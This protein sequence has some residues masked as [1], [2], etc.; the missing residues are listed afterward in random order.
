MT[1]ICPACEK[2]ALVPKVGEESFPYEGI[3]LS[4]PDFEYSECPVCREELVL[5]D[6]AR[7]NEGRI[8]DAKRAHDGLLTSSDIVNWR[9][10]WE[11]T[12][13]EAAVLLGGGAN[14]FSKYERGEVIQSKAMD[15]L[16]RVS[17]KCEDARA[18][19]SERAGIAFGRDNWETL[20]EGFIQEVIS[21]RAAAIS[22]TGCATVTSIALR[23]PKLSRV[24]ATS[25]VVAWHSEPEFANA[26]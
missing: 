22:P 12:Q 17:D 20:S 21:T 19:L 9:K 14:A 10:R 23:R 2:G 13:Q 4:I 8:A 11:L 1:N 18:L 5:A 3:R 6:Q 24:I 26:R 15:L 7:R 16:I 25:D